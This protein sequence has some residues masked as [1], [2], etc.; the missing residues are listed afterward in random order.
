MF[1]SGGP[2]ESLSQSQRELLIRLRRR[3]KDHR[4]G[5]RGW[6]EVAPELRL[7][8]VA[9]IDGGIAATYLRKVCGVPSDH[10]G[11]WMSPGKAL[12]NGHRPPQK[13]RGKNRGTAARPRVLRVVPNPGM[14]VQSEDVELTLRVG[15]WQLSLRLVEQCGGEPCCQ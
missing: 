8:V 7:E 11:R 10:L 14:A 4:L 13:P 12:A 6:A 15:P 9:A 5:R 3:L 1:H 2:K